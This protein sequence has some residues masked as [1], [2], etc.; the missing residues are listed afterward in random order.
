M[1]SLHNGK[2]KI[3][4]Q[5]IEQWG[6]YHVILSKKGNHSKFKV[7][8]LVAKVFIP[9]PNHYSQVNHIDENKEN[10]RVDNLEWCTCSYN[11]RYSQAKPCACFKDGKLVKKYNTIKDTELDGFHHGHVSMCC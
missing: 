1:K 4:K 2:E 10:N 7:H 11:I 6:Y 3:L 9:N 8:Q 5:G